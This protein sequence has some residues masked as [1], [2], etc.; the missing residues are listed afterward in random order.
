MIWIFK[1]LVLKLWIFSLSKKQ[2]IRLSSQ[3]GFANPTVQEQ[4]NYLDV[5]IY[6]LTGG[7]KKNAERLL[8]VDATTKEGFNPAENIEQIRNWL[9]SA[10]IPV[11][12]NVKLVGEAE[13][14]LTILTKHIEGLNIEGDKTEL[15]KLMRSL[16]T[17]SLDI[18][19]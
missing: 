14:T 10:N 4:F 6:K 7:S 9:S 1:K 11:E 19:V 18:L 12:A 17:E 2:H 16:Y 5:G 8:I 15:S 3:L 13:D